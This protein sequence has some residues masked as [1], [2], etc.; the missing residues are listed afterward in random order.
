MSYKPVMSLRT[1]GHIVA[2]KQ[3]Q[4]DD[5]SRKRERLY[6]VRRRQLDIDKVY[7]DMS[8]QRRS[9]TEFPDIR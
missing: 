4:K 5:Q 3:L 2:Y 1:D 8:I 7:P 6:R 9:G